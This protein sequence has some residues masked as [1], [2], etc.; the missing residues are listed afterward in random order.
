MP[1]VKY[2][3]VKTETAFMKLCYRK[4]GFCARA[5]YADVYRIF[6]EN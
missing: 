1:Y 5:G 3:M 6:G 4:A 2:G